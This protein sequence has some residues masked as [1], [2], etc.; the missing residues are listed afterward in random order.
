MAGK[1]GAPKTH[2][3]N[4]GGDF[5]FDFGRVKSVSAIQSSSMPNGAY[6]GVPSGFVI[7]SKEGN[8]YYSGDTALTQDMKLISETTKLKFAAL[9]IGGNFTMGVDDAVRA[10]DFVKCD[11]VLGLH[12][13][14][15]PEIKINRMIAQEKFSARGKTL[16]LLPIKATRDFG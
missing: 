7:E 9:C 11:Q 2:A 12:Y 4:P 8:F 10:A 16:H 5:E 15:F 6:G 3:L 14:T 1:K 13:D